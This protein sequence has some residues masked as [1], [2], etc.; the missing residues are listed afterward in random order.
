MLEATNQIRQQ[1]EKAVPALPIP[2]GLLKTV[3]DFD[4]FSAV[5]N[6]AAESISQQVVAAVCCHPLAAR[7]RRLGAL[8]LGL[9]DRICYPPIMQVAAAALNDS[10]LP[11]ALDTGIYNYGSKG[12][13]RTCCIRTSS[14]FRS[15]QTASL[16]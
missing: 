2:G 13:I 10:E 12:A 4:S 5:R 7:V 15:A 3:D 8:P 14:N 11:A 1:L 16:S 6:V 9:L